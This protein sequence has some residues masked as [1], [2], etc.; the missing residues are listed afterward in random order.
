MNTIKPP[1]IREDSCSEKEIAARVTKKLEENRFSPAGADPLKDA[2]V[3]VFARYSEILLER[4][5]R[6]PESH[7]QAFIAMLGA[8]PAPAVPARVPLTFKPV[9]STQGFA[10]V[11]PK[12]TQVSAPAQNGSGMV[13]FETSKD[14]PLVQ[15]ELERAVA[16]DTQR[17]VYADV[18][19]MGAPTPVAGFSHM[20]LFANPI[21]ME[22]ALHIAQRDIIGVTAL[23][24]LRLKIE[25]EYAGEL[26]PDI[27]IE[28][29]IHSEAGFKLLKPELDTTAGLTQS[30]ELVFKPPEKWPDYAIDSQALPWL[31]CRLQPKNRISPVSGG[32]NKYSISIVRIELSALARVAAAPIK[33]AFH[34]GIPLDLS[35]D[36]FPLGERPR[37]GDVFYA[38]SENFAAG[39]TQ[40]E[41]AIKLTNPP[42][43]K[44]SPIPVVSSK[45]NPQLRWDCH[46]SHGWVTLDCVDNTRALTQDGKLIFSVPGDAAPAIING[47]KGGCIRARMA[48][49]HYTVG[50]PPITNEPLPPLAPPSIAQI[51]LTSNKEFGPA[52]PEYLV[53]QSNFEYTKIGTAPALPFVP[54]PLHGEKGIV[55]YLGLQ[56]PGTKNPDLKKIPGAE[57]AGRTISFYSA[58]CDDGRRIFSRETG[59][60]SEA[61]PR[62]QARGATG[63]LECAVDDLTQGFRNPGIVEV[64]VPGGI[65]LWNHSALDQKCFWLRIIWDR[66]KTED[67]PPCPRRLLVN[68][69]LASQTMRLDNELLGSSNGRLGQVFHA[70]H[71]PI[72]GQLMLEVR[73]PDEK[74]NNPVE[75]VLNTGP[76]HGASS[77]KMPPPV[78]EAWTRWHEVDDFSGSDSHSRDFIVDRLTGH[79]RFGDGRHGR[80]P[81]PGANNIRL[82]EYHA[83]GGRQGNRPAGTITR[84]HTT[85]PYV[86]SVFNPEA[87]TGGQD[88]EN[89]DSLSLRANAQIRHRDRAVCIDDYADLARKASP[90]V[91][92]ARCVAAR[93]LLDDPLER[94]VKPGVVSVVI[95]PHDN[96][97]EPRPQPSFELVKN[98]KAFLDVRQPIGV[99]LIVLGPE[100]VAINAVVEISWKADHSA[101]GALVECEKRLTDFLH[102][103]TGGPE[104]NGW[105]FGERP[106]ASDLY[107]LLGAVEGLDYIR[108]LELRSDEERPGLLSTGTFLICSGKHEI[109]LC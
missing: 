53:V 51:Q 70:L 82:R 38:F 91:A 75:T 71:T 10:A 84:L 86:E 101:A 67:Q 100:Y 1:L 22:R 79:I 68:T 9:E 69:V 56:T 96:G 76:R 106:H 54:F 17:L 104:G 25:L 34:G 52:Q 83:G 92:Y 65:S 88:Q 43:A 66:Q 95:V 32:A 33:N 77:F 60:Q 20:S 6:I 89:P 49:G 63:W 64:R 44:D 97:K 94:E 26:S 11:V 85:V 40:I 105:Q 74:S 27:E 21:P 99:D 35:R 12:S 5:N 2:L 41:L 59:M 109:R 4:L 102:P 30:G 19:G 98:V 55:L 80:I 48:G 62:W 81:P 50:D 8:T 23:T 7:R 31:T 29:G 16:I 107:P 45:G 42:G 39:G 37:F 87:A 36:F 46:T 3:N 28:W 103:L 57:L 14:L 78:A 61:G 58:P 72:I 15:A 13:V 73:E 108:T 93:D 24:E 18:S 90:E 47:V